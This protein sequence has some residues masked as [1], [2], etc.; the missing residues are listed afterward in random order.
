MVCAHECK[1]CNKTYVGKTQDYLNTRTKQHI[2]DVWKVIETGRKNYGDD[3][4]GKAEATR[5]PMHSP[6][7]SPSTAETVKTVTK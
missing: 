2:H 6:N 1:L 5:E 3:W 4:Y 7:I